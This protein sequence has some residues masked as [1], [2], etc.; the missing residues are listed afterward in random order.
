[1][2]IN[3][4]RTWTADISIVVD[5]TNEDLSQAL[6]RRQIKAKVA[7]LLAP[8]SP[9]DRKAVLLDLI[10]EGAELRQAAVAPIEDHPHTPRAAPK[11]FVIPKAPEGLAMKLLSLV[12]QSPRAP[13]REYARELYGDAGTDGQNKTRSLLNALKS[14]KLANNLEPGKW[15]ATDPT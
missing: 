3:L 4:R 13:I 10:T 9:A 5:I 7:P 1:M 14:R 6:L 12:R 11:T 2:R 15:V 8:L